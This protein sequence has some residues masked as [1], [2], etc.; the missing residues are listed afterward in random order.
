METNE[1]IEK[2]L[3]PEKIKEMINDIPDEDLEKISKIDPESTNTEDLKNIAGGL[4]PTT[5]RYARNL[6]LALAAGAGGYLVGKHFNSKEV[7]ENM[8]KKEKYSG[9]ASGIFD[10]MFAQMFKN[11]AK[12]NDN[13]N[14]EVVKKQY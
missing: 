2:N 4:S 9:R 12:N 14:L 13:N 1:T 3:T 11:T 7:W 8:L 6:S 10:T 5:L